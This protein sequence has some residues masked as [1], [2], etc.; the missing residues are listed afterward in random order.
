MRVTRP[1]VAAAVLAL[2]CSVS[3]AA[4]TVPPPTTT[5]EGLSLA[6]TLTTL[7]RSAGSAPVG[8]ALAFATALEVGTT[9][10]VTSAAGFIYKVDPATGLRVRQAT[11]FGPAFAERALTSGEGKVSAS[12]SLMTATYDKL[13]DLSLERMQLGKVDAPSPTVARRGLT[14]LVIQAETLVMSGTMGVTDNLDIGVAVPLVQVRLDGISWV[15][16]GRGDVILHARA[17]GSSSGLGDIALT[18]KYR[19][20][21]FGEG[22]PDPGGIAVVGT[23]RLPTGESDNFRGLGISRTLVSL[24]GSSGRGRFRPHANVGFEYW[25]DGI[26]VITDFTRNTTVT[27]RH[28]LLYGGGVELEATP[29][30]TVMVDVLG[31]HIRGAGRVGFRTDTPSPTS[32]LAG[33]GVTSFESAVALDEGIRKLT[34]APGLK[35]NLKGNLLLSLNALVA[36]QDNGL[37]DRFTPVIGLDW[38]F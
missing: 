6:Q 22:P 38:T 14:S 8:E 5:A 36:L 18:G 13:G 10:L 21:S 28:Q 20:W 25:S 17:E 9:P 23:M 31:R 12:V 33:L 24:V 11:T 34:L 27:A 7:T 26:D 16:N 3:V 32:P 2:A 19:L 15:E 4:Q 37:H 1:V 35:L 30:V 29:K